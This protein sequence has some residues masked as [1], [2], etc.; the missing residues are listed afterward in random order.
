[1]IFKKMF[2]ILILSI[3]IN[4]LASLNVFANNDFDLWVKDFKIQALNSGIS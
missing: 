1:M 2:K 4:L 3:Y